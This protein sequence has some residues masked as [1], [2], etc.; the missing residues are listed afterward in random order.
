MKTIDFSYFIERYISGEMNN[1]EKEWFQ[2]ELDGNE[3]LRKELL[4]RKRTDN[5]LK[6]RDIMALRNKLSG[7]EK[8]RAAEVLSQDRTRKKRSYLNYAATI[9]GVIIILGI[10]LISGKKPNNDAIISKYYSTY[11]PPAPQRSLAIKANDN[12]IMGLKCY[13]EG[14][15]AEAIDLFSKVPTDDIKYIDAV[16]LCGISCC[17]TGEFKEAEQSFQQVIMDNENYYMED[18]KWNL[19]LCY[20]KTG[21]SDLAFNQ[22]KIVEKEGGIYSDN[23]RKIIRKIK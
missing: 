2:K 5:V 12:Y 14:E 7:I 3:Q 17:E 9:A 4:L 20:I 1:A 19:A 13:N 10:A 15:Y 11:V 8:K 6:D 21:K 23:A 16:F 18:A 22:L